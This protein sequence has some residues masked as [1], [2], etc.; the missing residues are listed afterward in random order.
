MDYESHLHEEI[1]V[2]E[3]RLDSDKIR[4]CIII[5]STFDLR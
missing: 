3:G 2:G 5:P 4:T 1:G